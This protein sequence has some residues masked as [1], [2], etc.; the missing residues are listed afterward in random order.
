MLSLPL[1]PPQV[2]DSSPSA[3]APARGPSHGR[4]F[5]TNFSNASPSHRL[6]LFT[7]CPSVGPFPQGAVLQE[8]AAPAWVHTGSQ[9]LPANLLRRGLLSPQVR[10][11]WQEPA[12][13]QAPYGVTAS[14]RHPPAPAWGPFHRLQVD[15]CSTVDLHGLKGNNLP[16]RGLQHKLQGK[17]LCSGIWTTSSPS[18][19]TEL[20]VCRVVSF[21]S[22]HSSLPLSSPHRF[23]LPLLKDVITESLPPSLIDLTSG[24]SVLEPAGIGSVRHGGSFSQLLTEA[25]PISPPLPK[26]CHTNP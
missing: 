15:I 21:T 3:P 7:N 8:Q 24:G 22:S 26:P 14:F 19:F 1:L 18:F 10:R 17:T 9:A 12:P 16:H 2:E 13:A 23:F 25:T 5:S 20:G 4:Q 11:S 6:Q